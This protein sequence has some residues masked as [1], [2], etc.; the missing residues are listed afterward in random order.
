MNKIKS[1]RA[2]QQAVESTRDYIKEDKDDGKGKGKRVRLTDEDFRLDPRRED[3]NK[4][5]RN[6]FCAE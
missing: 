6:L 4:E 5:L 1:L 3:L 2:E